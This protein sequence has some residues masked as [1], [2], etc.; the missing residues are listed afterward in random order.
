MNAQR[1]RAEGARGVLAGF[2]AYGLWGLLP[3][4]FD[5]LRPM[6]VRF[7][8]MAEAVH[9]K[10]AEGFAI[11]KVELVLEWEKQEG[12]GAERGRHGWGAEAQYTK[13]PGKWNVIARPLLRPWSVADPAL[14]PTAEAYV[15]DLGYWT[16]GSARGDGADRLDTVFGPQPPWALRRSPHPA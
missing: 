11:E 8:G 1:W 3:I 6:L 10:L 12:R 16:R 7:P 14:G 4:Y 9:A 13:R 5:A 2:G 15:K